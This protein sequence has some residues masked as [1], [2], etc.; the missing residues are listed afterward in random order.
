MTFPL[1]TYRRHYRRVKNIA[2]QLS[3][4]G[5]FT[6]TLQ[7]ADNTLEADL[8]TPDAKLTMQFVTVMRRFLNPTDA[9]YLP[10]VWRALAAEYGPRIPVTKQERMTAML[11]Q[12]SGGGA[13]RIEINGDELTPEKAYHL[14]AEGEYFGHDESAREGLAQ[15]AAMPP[16]IVL[17]RS[18]FY[19]YHLAAL[20]VASA[21]GEVLSDVERSPSGETRQGSQHTPNQRCLFCLDTAGPFTSEEHI[22]PEGMGSYDDVL[23]VGYVCDACNNGVLSQLDQAL[24]NC[25]LFSVQRV[26][27][28]PYT[29]QGTFPAA[30]FREG[31]ITKTAPLGLAIHAEEETPMLSVT[32]QRADGQVRFK[33]NTT[34]TDLFDPKRLARALYK[35]G[36]EY[37]AMLHGRDGVCAAA[38]DPA[39]SFV[40]HGGDFPNNLIM[41]TRSTLSSKIAVTRLPA[42]GGVLLFE[43]FGVQLC[44][45]LMPDPR[46]LPPPDAPDGSFATLPLDQAPGDEAF[47]LHLSNPT[48]VPS[49]QTPNGG[50]YP[51]L[52][53]IG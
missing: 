21:I 41:T 7:Y 39:R 28:V 32:E 31:T 10:T 36:L 8:T 5:S 6:L 18:A 37:L 35:V 22:I 45:N 30:Q 25:G 49:D 46:I 1:K 44:L 15:L 40:L 23:P 42:P 51:P 17:A 16:A 53:G 27:F 11:S 9:L 43:I 24:V 47:T 14:L 38:F 20:Q 19:D 52:L 50:A 13:G 12:L 29:K 48:A 34:S 3:K 2:Q 4:A 26:L 33:L